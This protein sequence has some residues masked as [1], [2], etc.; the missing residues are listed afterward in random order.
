MRMF[1]HA[2]ITISHQFVVPLPSWG[3][4]TVVDR[5]RRC[6]ALA[7][8]TRELAIDGGACEAHPK[9]QISAL[10][11]ASCRVFAPAA[12][13]GVSAVTGHGAAK[14]HGLKPVIV[15][16]GPSF[17]PTSAR[18]R[19]DRRSRELRLTT[20]PATLK[21]P[22][23]KLFNAVLE[24]ALEETQKNGREAIEL[25]LAVRRTDRPFC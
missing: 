21:S 6:R 11:K 13:G 5:W 25:C 7:A 4:S 19:F 24:R 1:A 17:E 14:M 12:G 15:L 20:S 18:S 22:A 8:L 16:P 9:H 3:Q 23:P 10:K 2:P